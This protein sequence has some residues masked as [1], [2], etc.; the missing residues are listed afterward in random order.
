MTYKIDQQS[1]SIVLLRDQ[2]QTLQ[3]LRE[4]SMEIL[5]LI[6]IISL[7]TKQKK[8]IFFLNRKSLFFFL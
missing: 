8:N 4:Q 3:L 5:R 1:S 6:P 7:F 2:D